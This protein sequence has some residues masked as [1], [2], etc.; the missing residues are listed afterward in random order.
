MRELPTWRRY[1][2]LRQMLQFVVFGRDASAP[3]HD[4]PHVDR[5]V[6]ISATEVRKRV[7]Q[8]HSIRY[9]VPDAVREIIESHRLYQ[10]DTY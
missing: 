7:A 4:F 2:E 9:L 1:A 6:D 8:G 10:G 5:R 3:P